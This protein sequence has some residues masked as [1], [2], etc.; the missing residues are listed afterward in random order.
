MYDN[1]ETIIVRSSVPLTDN[2]KKFLDQQLLSS[3][4]FMI[5]PEPVR[6]FDFGRASAID[7]S[8]EMSHGWQFDFGLPLQTILVLL[9]APLPAI[10]LKQVAE[11]AGKDFWKGIKKLLT[12]VAERDKGA[13]TD[14]FQLQAPEVS[15]EVGQITFVMTY[16]NARFMSEEM[17]ILSAQQCLWELETQLELIKDYIGEEEGVDGG[18][19]LIHAL[20][21]GS[22]DTQWWIGRE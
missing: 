20:V 2:E 1:S 8:D 5:D 16:L 4:R 3:S 14:S 9:L 11:E 19:M 12:R 6:V 22:N 17:M 13:S 10:F 18:G 21:D 15:F 7:L